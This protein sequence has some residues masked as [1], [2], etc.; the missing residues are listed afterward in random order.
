MFLH[1]KMI[2]KRLLLFIFFGRKTLQFCQPSD[3]S[4]LCV[5]KRNAN[6]ANVVVQIVLPLE[7]IMKEQIDKMEE[8]R[9]PSM[10]ANDDVLLLIGEAKIQ[11]CFQKTLKDFLHAKFQNMLRHSQHPNAHTC[12]CLQ[13]DTCN[14]LNKRFTVQILLVRSH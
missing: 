7:S 8:L 10:S 14:Q 2:R 13:T 6:D 4:S 3:V 9:I 1:S 5:G 12:C 11:A